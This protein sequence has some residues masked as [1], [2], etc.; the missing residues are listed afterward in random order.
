MG[1]QGHEWRR[2]QKSLNIKTSRWVFASCGSRFS[3]RFSYN[4]M[5]VRELFSHSF[6]ILLTY[7]DVGHY[8]LMWV[9]HPVLT[10]PFWSFFR[11]S[12]KF[13]IS[14]SFWSENSWPPSRRTKVVTAFSLSWRGR[15]QFTQRQLSRSSR[16]CSRNRVT[17]ATSGR[18]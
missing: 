18:H 12:A 1:S 14:R 15:G 16:V 10:H 9:I 3:C 6:T 4:L 2:L 8:K 7:Y 13:V 5:L 11:S 17:L